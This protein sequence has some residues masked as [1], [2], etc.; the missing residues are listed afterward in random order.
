MA[1][2]APR[3]SPASRRT[4]AQRPAVQRAALPRG[5]ASRPPAGGYRGRLKTAGMTVLAGCF[6]LLTVLMPPAALLIFI[7]V[8][9]TILAWI[10]EA[11]ERR[12]IATAVGALNLAGVGLAVYFFT[13]G[14][15]ETARLPRYLSQPSVWVGMY[16]SAAIGWGLF[17]TIPPVI[18]AADRFRRRQRVAELRR[19]RRKLTDEWGHE[20]SGPRHVSPETTDTVL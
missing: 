16:G 14:G 7:G 20:I 4:P 19:F 15:A 1:A 5:A 2:P 18:Q 11:P 6:L 9:P 8:M 13:L 10:A 3:T 17:L 12:G